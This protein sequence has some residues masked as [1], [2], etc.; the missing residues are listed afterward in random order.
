MNLLTDRWIPVR[1]RDGLRAVI[2][3]HEVTSEIDNPIV[4]LDFPRP[5]F[6]GAGLEWLIGIFQTILCD[7]DDPWDEDRWQGWKDSPPSPEMILECLGKH[8]DCFELDS[9]GPKFMQ[10]FHLPGGE[11]KDIAQ[12]FIDNPG[13]QTIRR[14]AD[15]FLKRGWCKA[16]CPSCTAISLYTLQTYAPSGGAGHRTSLR[17]GGP[18][19]TVLLGSS[20]WETIWLNVLPTKTFTRLSGDE[21]LE[22]LRDK[23][24]WMGPTRTSEKD[25]SPIA[26]DDAHPL[27]LYWAMPRRIVIDWETRVEGACDLCSQAGALVT[28]YKT[29]NYGNNYKNGWEHPLTPY[30]MP[31]VG[32]E[33]LP[34]HGQPGGIG[35]RHWMGYVL[36]DSKSGKRPATV[37]FHYRVNRRKLSGFRLSVFGYDMDNMKARSWCFAEMPLLLVPNESMKSY[38][39]DVEAMVHVAGAIARNT[40]YRFK[41]AV[42]GTNGQGKVNSMAG[43]QSFVEWEFW[44]KTEADFYRLL[45]QLQQAHSVSDEPAAKSA[46]E[47]WL[48]ILRQRSLEMFDNYVSLDS[49]DI[50]H[51]KRKIEAKKMLSISNWSWEYQEKLQLELTEKQKA[52]KLQKATGKKQKSMG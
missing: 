12:L 39:V 32:E 14:N 19:S 41:H 28:Q 35:Y 48:D 15:H 36:E 20:L 27:T 22:E 7:P 33:E 13:D 10:D 4:A 50:G 2:A 17:G 11:E 23:F 38:A 30:S 26:A 21:E 18:I 51:A 42:V 24:P 8:L 9:K 6:N 16:L 46:K 45:E 34:L 25:K 47:A 31:K 44:N 29:Q 5:D 49:P 52:K 40:Q 43:D 1:R 3:P 37:I